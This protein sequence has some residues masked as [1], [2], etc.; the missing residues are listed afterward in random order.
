MYTNEEYERMGKEFV[1]WYGKPLPNPEHE[2][3]QFAYLLKLFLR[4]RD[5]K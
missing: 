4:V 1:E 2:P 3:K 5:I